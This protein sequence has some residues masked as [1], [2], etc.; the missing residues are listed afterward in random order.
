MP[1]IFPKTD[2]IPPLALHDGR[3]YPRWRQEHSTTTGGE[4]LLK[5]LGPML[6]GAS[7]QTIPLLEHDALDLETDL[8]TL[9]GGIN[10]FRGYDPRRAVPLGDNQS[11]LTGVTVHSIRAD[12]LALRLTGLPADFVT[13]KS[14]YLSIDDGI[15]LHLLRT[16]TGSVADGAGLSQEFEVRPFVH[17]SILVGQPVTLRYPCANFMLEKDSVSVDRSGSSRR[18]VSFTAIQVLT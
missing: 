6:W 7:Y 17:P 9:Q 8:L 14:D 3:I 12:R 5:D 11:L 2:L 13:S 1:L 15:N 18:A 4:T 10:L 16:A